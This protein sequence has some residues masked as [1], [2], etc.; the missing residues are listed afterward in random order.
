M[1]NTYFPT[2]FPVNN[3]HRVLLFSPDQKVPDY[4]RIP[5]LGADALAALRAALRLIPEMSPGLARDLSDEIVALQARLDRRESF[6][7]EALAEM[8][9]CSDRLKHLERDEAA[10][11]FAGHLSDA[12][13]HATRAADLIAAHREFTQLRWHYT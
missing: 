12:L 11:A 6:N 9:H 7:A 4:K 13:T 5:D 2:T 3:T 10:D 8:N 1:T